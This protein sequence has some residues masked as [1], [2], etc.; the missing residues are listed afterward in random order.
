MSS[1]HSSRRDFL[2]TTA[3]VAATTL[4]ATAATASEP[5]GRAKSCILLMLVGGPSQLETWD[6]KPDA[7]SEIRGPFRSI[8]TR[9]TGVRISEHLPRL[10]ERSHRY[11]IVRT[12]HHD[13]PPIHEAGLQLLQT[14]RLSTNDILYPHVGALIAQQPFVLLPTPLGNTG[15]GISN[16]QTAGA[17]GVAHDPIVE[18]QFA[19]RLAQAD[20]ERHGKTTFGDCCLRARQLVEGGT[21]CVVVN[22]FES[23]YDRITW[24]CHADRHS[25][26]S[27]LDDYRKTLCP[28]LD[29]ALAG[30]LDDLSQRGMLD[31]TLVVAMGEIG[32]S[33]RLNANGGR[34]HWTSCW[35]ILLAGGG[36]RGGQAIGASDRHAAEPANRPVHCRE[37]AATIVHALGL[38]D[39]RTAPIVESAPIRELF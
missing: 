15:I 12:V 5:R 6:P 38:P 21:R 10:A 27:T 23:V 3:A 2:C 35:S 13:A 11:A 22:M 7:P 16:G 26:A 4:S 17:L 1:Q 8:P 33:P 20:R 24:D 39:R 19:H 25:L 14:G 28:M 30:M 18:R 34:D 9:T 32:R 31:D 36:V 37:V 29:H